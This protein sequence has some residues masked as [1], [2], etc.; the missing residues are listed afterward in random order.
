MQKKKYRIGLTWAIVSLL[1]AI[2]AVALFYVAPIIDQALVASIGKTAPVAYNPIF[3]LLYGF[4]YL[5]TTFQFGYYVYVILFALA[6]IFF[7][8]M[9]WWFVMIFVKKQFKKVIAWALIL[10]AGLLIIDL[11]SCLALV[12]CNPV[13]LQGGE[14]LYRYI[15]ND[16]FNEYAALRLEDGVTAP[17]VFAVAL[18]VYIM[19]AVL[20]L[21]AVV[22]VLVLVKSILDPIQLCGVRDESKETCRERRQRV[23]AERQAKLDEARQKREDELIMYVNYRVGKPEREREYEEIC[24]AHGIKIE[25]KEQPKVDLP[26]LK[27]RKPAGPEYVGS[28]EYYEELKRTLPCLQYQLPPV[29]PKIGPANK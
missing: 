21:V 2:V 18:C 19:Y 3:S 8:V 17:F 28:E 29:E 5:F 7:G 26:C 12:P 9:I 22:A 23:R 1:L 6:V 27:Q 14:L 13:K 16:M 10:V 25:K 11:A 15:L 20:A 4:P 24:R